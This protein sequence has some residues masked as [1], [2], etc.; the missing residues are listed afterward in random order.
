[1]KSKGVSKKITLPKAIWDMLDGMIDGE[2]ITS[3]G[4]ALLKILINE[5]YYPLNGNINIKIDTPSKG[6][7]KTIQGF[8][9]VPDMTIQGFDKVPDKIV[10]GFDEMDALEKDSNKSLKGFDDIDEKPKIKPIEFKDTIDRTK[11]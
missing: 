10:L 6:H 9:E 11:P 1:M 8:D 5:G 4:Q 7:T 2:L 3:R